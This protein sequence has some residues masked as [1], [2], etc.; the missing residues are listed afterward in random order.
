MSESKRSIIIFQ[1]VI[2]SIENN[3]PRSPEALPPLF[4]GAPQ[5]PAPSTPR[6]SSLLPATPSPI[7]EEETSNR[8]LRSDVYLPLELVSRL[9]HGLLSVA[10]LY[11][12]H[13]VVSDETKYPLRGS[14]MVLFLVRFQ[15]GG[16]ILSFVGVGVGFFEIWMSRFVKC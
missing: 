7:P 1:A 13:P 11:I 5:R 3:E 12:V 10:D 14:V 16:S 6:P 9:V 15:I 2:N 8:P 4:A